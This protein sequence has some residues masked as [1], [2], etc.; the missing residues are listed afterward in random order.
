M[1]RCLMLVNDHYSHETEKIFTEYFGGTGLNNIEVTT[2]RKLSSE[3]LSES[4]M[5]SMT[6][7]GKQMLLHTA[8][9]WL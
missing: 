7:S 6:S 4:L 8:V 9:D 3:L 5:Q 2:F 1:A